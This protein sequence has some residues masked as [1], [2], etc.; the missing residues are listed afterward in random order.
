MVNIT[1][2]IKEIEEEMRRTQKNKATEYHLG[3]LKGKLARLRAQLLEPTAGAGSGGGTGFDVSKSGDARISLVGF[4]SVG[5]STFLSK[6]TKTKSEVAAY[7]FT[8]L[9]AIPGVLEYG[10]AEIQVLDLPGIIEGAA[11]GKGRG[12][13]VISAAKTSDLILMVLD[14]TK[15]AEQRALL[16]AELEAVGIRLNREPPNIYLKAKKAGGMKI[17]FQAPPKNLDEKMLY[18]ILRDYKMLNCEVLVR[19]ENATVDDFIDVIMKDH[20]KYIKCLYVYNK[21]DSVSL[22]FLDKLAR[23]PNTCVMSCELDLGVRDVVD[24]CWEELQLI[25]VYTKRKGVEPDF[26]EALIVRNQSTIEDVCDQ[27]HRTIKEQFKYALVWG[28]SAMH[29]PQRVGLGHVVADEDVVSIVT[30]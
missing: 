7:S 13:Q 17:T 18:N 15:R 26:S 28:Q 14:A 20:R 3:L 21:I 24:R 2:K 12:R 5:K 8:T 22:D 9:T 16:E 1:D 27:I 23:E 29:I 25:R 4:P 6:I 19:D 11:E 10:G 30:K